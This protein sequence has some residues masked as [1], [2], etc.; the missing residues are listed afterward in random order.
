MS[1]FFSVSL[2]ERCRS[3]TTRMSPPSPCVELSSSA[4]KTCDASAI[5]VLLSNTSSCLRSA[6][7]YHILRP[8]CSPLRSISS[9]LVL[10]IM[11]SLNAT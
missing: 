3:Y 2:F 11:L 1:Q 4:L 10:N 8:W 5:L 6:V 9:E 7:L